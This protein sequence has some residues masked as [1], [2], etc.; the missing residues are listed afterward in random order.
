[1]KKN[2]LFTIFILFSTLSFCQ[3][4]T[5]ILGVWQAKLNGKNL[6][7]KD[8][9][10][11]GA[12]GAYFMFLV[13]SSSNLYVIFSPNKTQITKINLKNLINRKEASKGTYAVYDS[14]GQMPEDLMM[15]FEDSN[16]FTDNTYYTEGIVD[17]SPFS[18]Y[19]NPETK[20]LQGL[21][22]EILFELVRVGPSW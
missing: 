15:K 2:I 1:M 13:Y 8:V 19:Y 20:R 21:N 14:L 7:A 22:K 12:K 9:G 17:G 10:M 16:T 5:K 4:N 6:L 18:F 3:S 11:T